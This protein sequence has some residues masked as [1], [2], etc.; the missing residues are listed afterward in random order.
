[1]DDTDGLMVRANWVASGGEM[2]LR[3]LRSAL[4]QGKH[5]N[6]DAVPGM[7]DGEEISDFTLWSLFDDEKSCWCMC[8]L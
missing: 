2:L 5:V 1:M 6:L 7:S 3:Y 4:G 8:V